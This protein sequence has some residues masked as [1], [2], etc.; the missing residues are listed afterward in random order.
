MMTIF[1]IPKPFS[2]NISIIQQNAI[3]SWLKMVP[4][5]DVILFG[6][7]EGVA[8]IAG[9]LG[10]RHIPNVPTSKFGTPMLDYVFAEAERIAKYDQL[11]YI[12]SD[13][14]IL[15]DFVRAI[16][17]IDIKRPLIVGRRTD[18]D[19]DYLLDFGNIRSI[20]KL[21][22]LV[23]HNGKL[24]GVNGIDYFVFWRGTL[25]KL[26]KFVVGR[27]GWDNWII[28][29][30]RSLEIPVVD[31]TSVATVIHQNHNYNH[32]PCKRG[33]KWDGPESDHN[34][35]LVGKSIYLWNLNDAN[36]VMTRDGLKKKQF[37]FRDLICM[38]I[39]RYSFTNSYIEVAYSLF[40]S[41]MEIKRKFVE[42][43][44]CH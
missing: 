3:N 41:L 13:I 9:K 24:Q 40:N 11:C 32:I 36:W 2:K 29:H 33:D 31:I 35:N 7:A 17:D 34:M 1:A 22:Y 30:A 43:L 42:G 27:R 26:P 8:E 37:V 19:L 14:I 21:M 5:C 10:I 23:A 28:Y 25:G 20:D 38:L 6:D 18:I 44:Y 16:N 39:L 15:A 4:Q 12:N